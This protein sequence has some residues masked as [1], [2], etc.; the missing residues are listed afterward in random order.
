MNKIEYNIEKNRVVFA[1][2]FNKSL[3]DYNGI[4]SLKPIIYFGNDFNQEL[5]YLTPNIKQLIL[6]KKFNKPLDS[7]PDNINVSRLGGKLSSG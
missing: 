4:I 6:G 1:D 5:L 7:L 2:D 3:G